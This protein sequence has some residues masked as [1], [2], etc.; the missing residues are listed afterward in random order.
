[1]PTV[2]I[3]CFAQG[4][5]MYRRSVKARKAGELHPPLLFGRRE[6]SFKRGFI[7]LFLLAI[8]WTVSIV[9]CIQILSVI[10]PQATIRPYLAWGMKMV[11]SLFVVL[12]IVIVAARIAIH[13]ADDFN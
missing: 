13:D 5:F 12:S 11:V 6:P 8:F 2:L 10:F 3:L 7:A 4:L 9:I 1:M